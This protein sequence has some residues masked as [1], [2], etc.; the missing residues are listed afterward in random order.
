MQQY[1]LG[2]VSV[3]FRSHTPE[4]ILKA[5]KHTALQCIEWGSD[6][7]APCDD[8]SRLENLAK[9]QAEYGITCC[10]YGTYFRLGTTPITELPQ[11]IRAAKILGTDILRLWCGNKNSEEYTETEK[12]QLFSDCKAAAALAEAAAADSAEGVDE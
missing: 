10:S 8:L 11:Y 2:L 3:S 12:E 6:V 1:H 4:E 5:M 9:L 7:H